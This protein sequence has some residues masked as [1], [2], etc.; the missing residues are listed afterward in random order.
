VGNTRQERLLPVATT[1]GNQGD[2]R[3]DHRLSRHDQLFGHASVED[4]AQ[5]NPPPLPGLAGGVLG[6]NYN[7]GEQ[8]HAV[9]GFD[10]LVA[11]PLF[12]LRNEF[13]GVA[14]H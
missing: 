12:D 1:D 9:G 7:M 3:I 4:H 6:G 11:D 14:F 2:V 10:L 13:R 8:N 5:Y